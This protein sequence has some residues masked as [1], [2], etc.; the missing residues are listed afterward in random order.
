MW[1]GLTSVFIKKHIFVFLGESSFSAVV[2]C[3]MLVFPSRIWAAEQSLCL[4]RN[5][6]PR[7]GGGGGGGGV[8][9]AAGRS[10]ASCTYSMQSPSVTWDSLKYYSNTSPTCT[11]LSPAL[12][13]EGSPITGAR[14]LELKGWLEHPAG[15]EIGQLQGLGIDM[16]LL[17]RGA[18]VAGCKR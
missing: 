9:V 6:R 11:W 3:E 18:Y 8:V 1:I 5:S 14:T 2:D 17:D 15:H 7:R 4:L 13:G 12:P 16:P 10:C